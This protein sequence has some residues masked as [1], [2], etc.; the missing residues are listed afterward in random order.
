M[1][2]TE[3]H[4]KFVLA[5]PGC[6]RTVPYIPAQHSTA[7]HRPA[8]SLPQSVLDLQQDEAAGQTGIGWQAGA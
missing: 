6:G 8:H 5:S 4:L 7:Q 1:R 3:G 2:L